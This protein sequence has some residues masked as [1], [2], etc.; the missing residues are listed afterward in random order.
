MTPPLQVRFVFTTLSR[1]SP[2]SEQFLLLPNPRSHD[3]PE[4][5][6]VHSAFRTS[7][8]S[9]PNPYCVVRS[10]PSFWLMSCS[11]DRNH[12]STHPL[13]M[14]AVSQEQ[15]VVHLSSGISCSPQLSASSL[16]RP[17]R[18]LLA[19]RFDL[20]GRLRL[21]RCRED[22][23]AA[24]VLLRLSKGVLEMSSRWRKDMLD[25]L[26]FKLWVHLL[27]ILNRAHSSRVV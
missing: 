15:P 10:W 11:S 13:T 25:V 9:P 22:G 14:A 1:F 19:G 23:S 8:I 27:H 18:G 3:L 12:L 7:T 6:V 21:H 16:V 20:L 26:C 2:L 24:C 17:C 5:M 4:L